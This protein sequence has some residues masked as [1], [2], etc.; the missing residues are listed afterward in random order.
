M[1]ERK[2]YERTPT[3][4]MSNNKII[5]NATQCAKD[6]LA[7]CEDI[8]NGKSQSEACRN[9]HINLLKFRR[10]I[11][12]DYH[13][14]LTMNKDDKEAYIEIALTPDEKLHRDIVNKYRIKH[15]YLNPD[16]M[17]DVLSP[18]D[19]HESL[20]FIIDKY[21]TDKEKN[22]LTKTYYDKLTGEQIG[23]QLGLSRQ[24]INVVLSKCLDKL[25]TKE[26]LD[27][28]E[29]GI[30]IYNKQIEAKN[31][32]LQIDRDLKNTELSKDIIEL[33]DQLKMIQYRNDMKAL[34]D[35]EKHIQELKKSFVETNSMTPT[36]YNGAD[37]PL[38]DELT[39]TR[40]KNAM[41][42]RF[43]PFRNKPIIFV[44]DLQNVTQNQIM[45]I[46]GVG[47]TVFHEIMKVAS[48]YNIKIPEF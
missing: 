6:I 26:N 47:E 33:N 1:Y 11:M 5:N 4:N 20:V 40:A 28:L 48:K 16:E 42:I 29:Y 39:S 24:F 43:A 7:V 22:V 8:K 27:I 46:P 19:L 18:N 14:V 15:S 38:V 9:H 41:L 17:T 3:I 35:L 2:Q 32:R 37:I 36:P 13:G 30:N 23:E 31:L 44:S 34:L 21:L 25:A 10:F 45:N 12:I